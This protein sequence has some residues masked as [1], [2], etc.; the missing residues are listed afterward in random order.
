[1]VEESSRRHL[2]ATDQARPADHR[3]ARGGH[4]QADQQRN[5]GNIEMTEAKKKPS[6][7]DRTDSDELPALQK[8][9]RDA[10]H[11]IAPDDLIVDPNSK[12]VKARQSEYGIVRVPHS[13]P[14]RDELKKELKAL[15][16]KYNTQ[17][18]FKVLPAD[19]HSNADNHEGGDVDQQ[20]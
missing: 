16:A 11:E 7:F 6:V 4:S 14:Q 10:G 3:V 8:S 15:A 17:A 13:H 5:E 2:P 19:Q 20:G 1:M 9:F 12:S 18:F